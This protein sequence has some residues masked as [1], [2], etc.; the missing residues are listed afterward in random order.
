[1]RTLSRGWIAALYFASF[2]VLGAV[3]PYLALDLKSRGLSGWQLAIAMGMLPLGRLVAGPAWSMLADRLQI[4]GSVLRIA[5]MLAAAGLM[6]TS[7][8]L[9]W[10]ASAALLVLSIGRAPMAPVVDGMALAVL[11]DDRGSYGRL[12]RWGSIGFLVSVACVPLLVEHLALGQL[13]PGIVLAVLTALLTWVL[14]SPPP[15]PKRSILPALRVLS[16][17]RSLRWILAASALHFSAHVAATSFL[18]VHMDALSLASWW[19]GVA[20][21]VGVT[22]EIGVMSSAGWLLSRF[23]AERVF[24]FATALAVVRWLLTSMVDTGPALV[25]CQS[26]HGITFGAFW[27]SG[28]ALVAD[29]APKA[30]ATSA[31]GLLA[32]AVGGVGSM[33]GLVG[34]S[35][36]VE[37]ME[38][39]W[40]FICGAGV[41]SLALLCALMAIRRGTDSPAGAPAR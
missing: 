26:L 35:R 5:T 31:Q 17:N 32:A 13:T 7:M 36:V 12:R 23:S 20:L 37:L 4:H 11:G 2:S 6:G 16:R 19:A 27:I 41:G 38:T 24:L 18:A 14:P 9:G 29:R 21:A 33:I 28:V 1:M 8:V 22:V 25:A 3:M 10:W 15:S 34:A 40:L 39:R 30:V